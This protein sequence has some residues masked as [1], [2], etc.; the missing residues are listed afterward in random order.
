MTI[1]AGPDTD[2]ANN[3]YRRI[4]NALNAAATGDTIILSGT[5]NFTAPFAAAAWAAGNDGIAG[6]ADDYEVSAPRGINNVTLTAASL[7]SATIQGPGD[8]PA[9]DLEAFLVFDASLAPGGGNQGW[10]I[11]KLRILD[12]DLSIGMFA[13]GVS[14][15]N[16]TLIQNNF[17]R[18]ATDLNPTVAPNDTIQN[19][20]LHFSFGTNQSILGNSFQVLGDG[21]SNGANQSATVVMQSNTSGG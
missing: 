13:V 6:N 18:I 16:N 4:Q 7:G 1:N 2:A 8:L 21:V 15:Y 19:I 11:S 14:D 12:F 5:F 10:T 3:D 9:L 17:I 20:G